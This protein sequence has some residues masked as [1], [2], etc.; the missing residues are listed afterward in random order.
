[1]WKKN[2]RRKQLNN[3]KIRR[4][5]RY[6]KRTCFSGMVVLSLILNISTPIYADNIEYLEINSG[7]T[8]ITTQNPAKLTSNKEVSEWQIK[9]EN[10]WVNIADEGDKTSCDI[11][12][13]KAKSF[14]DHDDKIYVRAK[15]G[16]ET[17]NEVELIV[18]ES[19]AND[20]KPES[21]SDPKSSG[22]KS[23]NETRGAP[24]E[25]TILRA[26]GENCKITVTCGN[27]SGIPENAQLKVEEILQAQESTDKATEY[28]KYSAKTKEALDLES[29][30]YKYARF[31]DISIQD[32]NGKEIQPAK[33]SKVSVKIELNDSKSND[34][35]IVH[36]G[37][38]TEIMNSKVKKGT[39]DFE[40]SGFSVY[41]IIDAPDP[42]A[43]GG[44]RALYREPKRVLFYKHAIY[45]FRKQNRH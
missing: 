27:E 2:S 32:S 34:L 7:R 9:D 40:T 22:I 3:K 37:Q 28:D 35:S 10:N 6:S 36:F 44:R 24:S 31:F 15:S 42:V 39:I 13:K 18:K 38:K 43:A 21:N 4:F 14:K 1:M 30:V 25:E 23:E 45:D 41:A 12:Y 16:N 26:D 5:F 33:G 20:E 19:T 11:T 29:E 17:S 8:E